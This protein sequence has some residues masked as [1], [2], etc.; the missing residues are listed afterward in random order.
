MVL[1]GR[2]SSA[3]GSA[4]ARAALQGRDYPPDRG[5]RVSGDAGARVAV[6]AP[7]RRGHRWRRCSCGRPIPDEVKRC[8]SRTCPEFAPIWARDT[9]RRL[10]VNLERVKLSVM[11]SVTAPGA[12]VFPFDVRYCTH[13]ADEKCSG[14]LGCRVDPDAARAFNRR[15]G[16]WW[17]QLHR[18]AKVRADRATGFKGRLAA[19]VWEKQ[20]RGLAH[21]HGVISVETPAHVAWAEA[22]VTSLQELAPRY[23]FGF[24]DGWHKIGRKFWP[25][26]Q[27]AAYLS[28]YFAGGR[29]RKMAI[30]ENVLAGDLPRLV[31]FVGRD[32]TG[33]TGC[34]MRSLRNARRLWASREVFA[35]PPR[36]SLDEWLAAAAMVGSQGQPGRRAPPP[37]LAKRVA[38]GA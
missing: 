4:G 13:S 33:A 19:R 38:K 30:T 9:R 10:F 34:T 17:S 14:S 24:V 15:A 29:G 12:N 8:S 5:Q 3:C 20:R 21:L 31:V 27:A 18:A 1:G 28:S 32:L 25:G 7:M 36:L 16:E 22:Y 37:L 6:Q 11:F 35:N 26:V 2:P 23:G